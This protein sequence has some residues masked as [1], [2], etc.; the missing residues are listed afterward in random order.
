MSIQ[1]QAKRMP[2][3]SV[4]LDLMSALKSSKSEGQSLPSLKF[5]KLEHLKFE[6]DSFIKINYVVQRIRCLRM[7]VD[8]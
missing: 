3:V 7:F 2:S 8:Q 4:A 5:F 6:D 1:K